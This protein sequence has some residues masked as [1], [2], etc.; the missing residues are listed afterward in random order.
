VSKGGIW[1]NFENHTFAPYC[2]QI[3]YSTSHDW[4]GKLFNLYN[5]TL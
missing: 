5:E 2:R 3:A 4:C 1:K